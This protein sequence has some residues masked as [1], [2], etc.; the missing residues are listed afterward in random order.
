MAWHPI[1]R[2]YSIF[3]LPSVLSV[4]RTVYSQS[5]L[6]VTRTVYSHCL[7]SYR[8]HVQLPDVG[9]L[10]GGG[11][12]LGLPFEEL[13]GARVLLLDDTNDIS[14]FVTREAINSTRSRMPQLV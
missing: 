10:G 11:G 1:G 4:T 5:V 14:R 8:S 9:L 6:L 3:S 12:L 7:A 13:V 2:T